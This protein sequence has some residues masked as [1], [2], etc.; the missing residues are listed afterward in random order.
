[1]AM[2][3]T[4][5]FRIYASA[6]HFAALA[7]VLVTMVAPH[8]VLA[9]DESIPH[10][11]A[12]A[13]KGFVPQEIE[14]AAAYFTGSGVVQDLQ[15]AAYWYEKAA[16][17]G[18]PEAE[19]EIGFLYQTG[20]GVPLDPARALHWY[21]LSAS[22]GFVKAK[23]NL[24]VMYVWGI[25]VRKNEDLAAQLFREATAN[26]SGAAAGYLGDMCYFGIGMKQDKAAA[27]NWYAIGAK[28][29]DPVAAYDL[30]TLFSIETDHPQDLSKAV[31]LLRE[32]VSSGY[33]PAMHSLGRLLVNHPEFAR[34]AQ[35][36]RGLLE[37]ASGAGS[38]KSTVLL[39]VLARDGKGAPAD[40]E[41]AFY[42]FQVAML[43]GG[44]EARRLLTNDMIALSPKVSPARAQV[45]AANAVAW[46]KQHSLALLFVYRKDGS[47][48]RFPAL[49][50]AVADQ[51]VH[52]GQLI[53]PPPS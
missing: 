25:A 9:A 20:A 14:L 11:Q 3:Q 36:S 27:E 44:D 22:S 17:S 21:Q 51:S 24:G 4:H 2:I 53:P 1:M 50:R 35:E 45:L 42:H 7:C 6:I 13:D 31:E 26:G 32:S 34:S 8:S 18:D 5:S 28:L 52:A 10:L 37:D 33:V 12:A 39:G 46:Y 41:T 40:P 38:W 43:Q 16:E 30:A 49:A 48:R 23:V 15:M 19:N 29:R 47:S